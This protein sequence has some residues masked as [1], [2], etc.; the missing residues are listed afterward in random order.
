MLGT[1]GKILRQPLSKRQI[2]TNVLQSCQKSAVKH[3]IR[4]PMLLSS[5]DLP[6][7]LCPRFVL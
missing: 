6:K 2:L 3:S 7:I 1:D 4:K 5:V